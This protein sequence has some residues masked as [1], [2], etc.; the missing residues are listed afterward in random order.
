MAPFTLMYGRQ[1]ILPF[2]APVPITNMPSASDYYSQLLRFLKQAKSTA[3]TKIK[4][5]QNVYKRT[6]DTGRQ[7]L[8]PLRPGQLVLIK[9][10][11]I[12]HLRKFSPKYYGHFKVIRQLRRLNYEVQHVNDGHSEKV[13][14]SRIRL[15]Q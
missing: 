13:H 6:Y 7:D 2:D 11:M 4:A 5:H 8:Q 1:P 12:K 3:W 15:I 10:M 14:V 9:Q